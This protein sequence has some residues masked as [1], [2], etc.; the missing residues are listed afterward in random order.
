MADWTTTRLN[1]RYHWKTVVLWGLVIM[2]LLVFMLVG[3]AHARTVGYLGSPAHNAT[4]SG[5]G[6]ISGWK[7]NAQDIT[8]RIDGGPPLDMA[9]GVLRT[10]TRPH[11]DGEAHNGFIMQVNWNSIGAGRHVA[12]A[13]DNGIEFDR[14]TF[15]VGTT[16]EEFL[17]GVTAAIE[18]PDFPRPGETGR[19]VWN[20]S[21]QHLELQE[22]YPAVPTRSTGD[23]SAFEF[24]LHNGDGDGNRWH[25]RLEEAETEASLAYGSM[26]FFGFRTT[27]RGAEILLGR[28]D[29]AYG[30]LAF[31]FEV[32]HPVDVLPRLPSF[33]RYR[34]AWVFP[35]ATDRD[36][37]Q[38]TVESDPN[39]H[40][41][42]YVLVFNNLVRD[43][44][45][46]LDKLPVNVTLTAREN[47]VCVPENGAEHLIPLS[48]AYF[49]AYTD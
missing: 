32:G 45:G 48:L 38:A 9:M 43:R 15:T 39:A 21:T 1:L 30:G 22:V 3:G 27:T 6:F 23:L 37:G 13:Y 5:I 8:V 18:V 10:D 14:N 44:H 42:C 40:T 34:Y 17:R 11:C 36:T 28:F 4:V 2:G 47:G 25:I 33:H 24:L 41:F 16:G 7:C 31:D 19:F 35:L 26:T 20:Q 46:E 29:S 49:D 12:V